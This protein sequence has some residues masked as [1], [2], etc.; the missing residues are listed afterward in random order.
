MLF[1]T[2]SELCHLYI[3]SLGVKLRYIILALIA[4]YSETDT[5]S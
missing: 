1:V 4:H 3:K 2:L 5:D